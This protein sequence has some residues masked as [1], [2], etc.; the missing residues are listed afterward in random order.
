MRTVIVRDAMRIPLGKQGEDN[1]VRVVWP[2]IIESYVKLYGGGDFF[3][4]VRRPGDSAPYPAVVAKDGADLV[5]TVGSADTAKDGYGN[6]ELTYTVGGVVAK[7][8]T[9]GIIINAS[10]SGQEP[11]D[12]PEPQKNW[13]D[14]VLAAGATAEASVKNAQ[15]AAERAVNGA[16]QAANAAQ[17]AADAAAGAGSAAQAASGAAQESAKSAVKSEN[18]AEHS[19]KIG[20]NGNWFLWNAAQSAFVDTGVRAEGKDGNTPK[21]TATK[22]GKITSIAA[23]GVEIAQVKDGEAATDISL[24][25]TAATVGQ[26]IKVKAVDTDGKPTAWEAV[27]MAN[28]ESETWEFVQSFKLAPDT[29][30]YE[31]A[32]V[33]EYRA[34]RI[35]VIR[36][37][38]NNDLATGNCFLRVINPTSTPQSIVIAFATSGYK[39]AYYFFEAHAGKNYSWATNMGYGNN[40]KTLTAALGFGVFPELVDGYGAVFGDME[41]CVYDLLYANPAGTIDGAETVYVYGVRR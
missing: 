11:T 16:N 25:L 40:V 32:N 3:L 1:A 19:P 6:V 13:V 41:K 15:K 18:A 4:A 22:T 27:D 26:T 23:D 12:P 9:W 33:A 31:L 29:A 37:T 35:N 28:G 36:G 30:E 7:S 20:E 21:I 10:L 14:A 39:S 34:I 5:W 38:Q 2:G 24:G 17:T 8:Q